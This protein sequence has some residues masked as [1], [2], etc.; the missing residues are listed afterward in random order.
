MARSTV[1]FGID[2]GTTNSAVA[3]RTSGEIHVIPSVVRITTDRGLQVGADARQH[4][5]ADPANTHAEF[6]RLMGTTTKLRFEETGTTRTPEEL[7]AEVLRALKERVRAQTGE[8]IDCAVITVPALF[9]IPQNEATE[10]AAALAGITFAPLLQEPIAAALA[11]GFGQSDLRRAFWLVYDF[12]GGTFDASI[13][14]LRDGRLSVVDHDGD[15]FLG[16][17]DLDKRLLDLAI[18][19]I[20]ER[21]R[22]PALGPEHEDHKRLLAAL[23][24]AA[25]DTR[26]ALSDQT[27]AELKVPDLRDD[28]SA[29]PVSIEIRFRREE[30]ERVIIPEIS[31]SIDICSRLLERNRLATDD[32]GRV[33]LV[34]G[35]T[36]TPL[37][38]RLLTERLGIALE[39]DLDPATTVARGAA[40]HASSIKRPAAPAAPREGAV[41]LRL[42]HPSV[43]QDASPYVVGRFLEGA[44]K[45]PHWV[46]LKRESDGWTSGHLPIGEQGAFMCQLD[47]DQGQTTRFVV[48]AGHSDGAEVAVE[49]DRFEITHGLAV[50][51]PPLSR[52]LGVGLADNT[53]VVYLAKGTSLPAQASHLHRTTTALAPGQPGA[54]IDVPVVQGESS[55]ADRNRHV[56]TLCIP[57]ARIRRA[58]PANSEVEVSVEVDSSSTVKARAYVPFIDQ[59]FEQVLSTRL[60]PATAEELEQ[61]LEL[62]FRRRSKLEESPEGAV[63]VGE[64]G[65]EP[66]DEIIRDI[67][68]A[69]L[70]DQDASMRA[71]RRLLELHERLD[72]AEVDVRWPRKVSRAHQAKV[73]TAGAVEEHG[74][75]ADRELYEA[76]EREMAVAIT[77]R[78]LRALERKTNALW[79]LRHRV[80]QR[81]PEY[82]IDLFWWLERRQDSMLQPERARQLSADGKA[83][84]ERQDY[85][86]LERIVLE[87]DALLGPEDEDRPQGLR[88]HV[89]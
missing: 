31:R 87:L 79:R 24:R 60:V 27:E 78:D 25:E 11:Y 54:V 53:V 51:A 57:A 37:I 83:A 46:E 9:E 1:D 12:G 77:A 59:V 74:G 70:G 36:R 68:A 69:S 42:E 66:F 88:S 63:V 40:L 35:V 89:R 50:S 67:A 13:V 2:L 48:T 8:D 33:V 21:H 75:H 62:S 16:G 49:P 84:L 61:D 18:K 56:G 43:S 23:R 55:R 19:R 73:S 7:S 26:I 14:S 71:Q 52:S 47:L 44:G 82:W 72:T 4:L 76:L 86:A 22:V 80:L 34:G 15:N 45:R 10:R 81:R 17:K 3:V 39:G 5:G 58:L 6:K 65:D 30:L 28:A 41:S 20:G 29:H 38:R 32:V 85:G 64:I